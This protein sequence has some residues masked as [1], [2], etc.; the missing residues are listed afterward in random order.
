MIP[1]DTPI[2]D[3]TELFRRI[4]PDEVIW[5][6]DE[7]RYRPSSG[8]FRKKERVSVQIQDALADA[9]IEPEATLTLSGHTRHSLA[10]LT[11][12][13][14]RKE[15][16]ILE[17]TPL[18][19]NPAHGEIVGKK[20]SSCATRLARAARWQVLQAEYIAETE[21]AKAVEGQQSMS[22]DS[23]DPVP[24]RRTSSSANVAQVPLS[25]PDKL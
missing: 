9:E 19:D 2:A 14:A 13:V 10:A 20:S 22:E 15:Q 23:L 8:A 3:A 25:N 24:A 6:D 5:D 21:S 11:A 7:G 1:V 18:S 16:Q 17:R 12:E 4:H